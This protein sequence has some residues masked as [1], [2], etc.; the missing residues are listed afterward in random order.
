M[1]DK[2]GNVYVWGNGTTGE[3]GNGNFTSKLLPSKTSVDKVVKVS[4]GVGHVGVLT[5]EGNIVTWGQNN[6]GQLGI[7]SSL[8]TAYPRK[9]STQVVDLVLG[10]YHTAVLKTDE[11]VY[12]TRIWRKWCNAEQELQEIY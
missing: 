2:E 7:N 9:A 12:V 3:L 10:G 5:M 8:V 1:V 11:N 6:V 4:M